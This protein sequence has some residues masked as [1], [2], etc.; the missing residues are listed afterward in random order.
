MWI[1]LED[2][3]YEVISEL[4]RNSNLH[5]LDFLIRTRLSEISPANPQHTKAAAVLAA[6]T[7]FSAND[8]I[9]ENDFVK[10]DKNGDALVMAWQKVPSAYIP[11]STNFDC[12]CS[13]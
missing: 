8:L 12:G 10:W 7:Y 13:K 6:Q 2:Q 5:G 9:I 3:E 4:L 11:Q 1:H